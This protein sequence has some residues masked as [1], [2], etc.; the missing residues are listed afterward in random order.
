MTSMT[1]SC[2]YSFYFILETRSQTPHP[3]QIYTKQIEV[4]FSLRKPVT[5][6]HILPETEEGC[7]KIGWY[8]FLILAFFC[9]IF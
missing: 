6:G 2:F 9:L 8:F 4:P 1:S 7:E 3:L 5:Q